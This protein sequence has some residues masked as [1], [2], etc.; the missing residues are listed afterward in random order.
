[1]VNRFFP[2]YGHKNGGTV[3]TVE[4][5]GFRDHKEYLRC[6]VGTK[7]VQAIF[8]T[9][10]KLHCVMPHS[11]TVIAPMPFRILMNDIQWAEHTDPSHPMAYFYYPMP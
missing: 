3:V 7:E 9:A 4:G 11:D 5:S 2:P 1:M 6:S 10:N 8:I